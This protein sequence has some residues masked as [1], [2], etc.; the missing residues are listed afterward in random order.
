MSYASIYNIT[1]NITIINSCYGANIS[2]LFI[3]VYN[4]SIPAY[5]VLY[6]LSSVLNN[7]SLA[8]PASSANNKMIYT[9]SALYISFQTGIVILSANVML[10]SLKTIDFPSTLVNYVDMTVDAL[11]FGYSY[12]Q[13][14]YILS[15]TN[16]SVLWQTSLNQMITGIKIISCYLVVYANPYIY[17]IDLELGSVVFTLNYSYPGMYLIDYI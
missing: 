13:T 11:L 9:N 16:F 5:Q 3:L 8:I 14:V 15:T 1:A 7:T 4:S 17:Q 2:E 12:N 6:F 10:T